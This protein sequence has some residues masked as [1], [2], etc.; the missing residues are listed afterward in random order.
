[1]IPVLLCL[2]QNANESADSRKSLNKSTLKWSLK[3]LVQAGC[4][5][6]KKVFT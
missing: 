6:E 5:E 1:V 4:G 3:L 2:L